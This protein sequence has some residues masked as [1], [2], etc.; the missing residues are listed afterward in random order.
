[1]LASLNSQ[2]SQPTRFYPFKQENIR[3]FVND[4]LRDP[5]PAVL[6]FDRLGLDDSDEEL[7]DSFLGWVLP[8]WR[9]T[10]EQVLESAGLDAYVVGTRQA[11]NAI[12]R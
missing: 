9:I 5:L 8:L 2:V 11:W 6:A 7:P 3:H 4:L 10:D 12:H 1:M